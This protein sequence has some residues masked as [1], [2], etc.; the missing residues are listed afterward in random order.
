M[1]PLILIAPVE[2]LVG[3][4][5]EVATTVVWAGD[6]TCVSVVAGF[7]SVAPVFTGVAEAVTDFSAPV[8]EAG[9]F[10]V[11]PVPTRVPS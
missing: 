2:L 3:V 9:M 10:A 7:V 8:V 4:V 11:P 1:F 6:T 5:V